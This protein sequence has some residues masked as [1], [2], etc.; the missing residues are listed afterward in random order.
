MFRLVVLKI[1]AAKK[2]KGNEFDSLK[3]VEKQNEKQN[4]KNRSG[5]ELSSRYSVISTQ[6]LQHEEEKRKISN[7][8]PAK[9][10]TERKIKVVK[11][12][13]E[14][15][16]V[17]NPRVVTPDFSKFVI[18]LL[19]SDCYTGTPKPLA[20]D[21]KGGLI[22]GLRNV[23]TDHGHRGPWRVDKQEGSASG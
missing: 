9:E 18:N 2:N 10:N 3:E 13:A 1:F 21:T 17:E 14:K 5:G 6:A 8:K 19:Y 7:S 15:I 4:V 22:Q 11:E 23:Y 16:G 20:D 12:F